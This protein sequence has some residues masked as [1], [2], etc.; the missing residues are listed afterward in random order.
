MPAGE[1]LTTTFG[2]DVTMAAR[3][4]RQAASPKRDPVDL[5]PRAE[6]EAGDAVPKPA[7]KALADQEAVPRKQVAEAIKKYGIDPEKADPTTV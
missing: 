7:L 4:T 2:E 6:G 1:R 3:T 5:P